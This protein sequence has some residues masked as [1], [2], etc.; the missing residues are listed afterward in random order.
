MIIFTLILFTLSLLLTLH[1]YQL[2]N[3][4]NK[5]KTQQEINISNAILQIEEYRSNVSNKLSK[6]DKTKDVKLS[7]EFNQIMGYD[8]SLIILKAFLKYNEST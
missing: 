6:K 7:P 4:A 5:L 8:S 3:K 2:Y 1:Y